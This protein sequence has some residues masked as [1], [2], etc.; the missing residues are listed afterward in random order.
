MRECSIWLMVMCYSLSLLLALNAELLNKPNNYIP[1]IFWL[2]L[3]RFVI[4]DSMID[5][6]EK[7]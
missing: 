4:Y 2:I 7:S 1:A 6:P 5:D 3:G